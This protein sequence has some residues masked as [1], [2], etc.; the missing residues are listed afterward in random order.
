MTINEIYKPQQVNKQTI[1][2]VREEKKENFTKSILRKIYSK[3][4]EIK[5][6]FN[7]L[8]EGLRWGYEWKIKRGVLSIGNFVFIGSNAYIIYPTVIGDLTLIA[9][10]LIIA[11]NDH[12]YKIP[13]TPM[14]IALPETQSKEIATTIESEVWIGQRCTIIHGIR[15][16]RGSIIAAGS[17]VTKDVPEYSVIAGVPAITIKKRFSPEDEIKH[18]HDLYK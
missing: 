12:G 4:L 6:D 2:R 3:Y 5:F 7:F 14:T 17:V 13:G 8:G 15:I 10:D 9:P 16:G 18:I 11:G 1:L